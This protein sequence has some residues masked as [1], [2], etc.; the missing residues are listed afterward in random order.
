MRELF[1][2]WALALA[3]IASLAFDL[4]RADQGDP[5]AAGY[6]DVSRPRPHLGEPVDLS[7]LASWEPVFLDTAEEPPSPERLSLR[8]R[9]Q[10]P[11]LVCGV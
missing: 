2:A 3:L 9:R 8:A 4:P 11:P 5:R 1:A 10:L 7:P 6:V